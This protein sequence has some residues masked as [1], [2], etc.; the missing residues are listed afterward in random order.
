MESF[1]KSL[2]YLFA[3]DPEPFIGF[4]VGNR[5]V[6]VLEPVPVALPARGREVDAS[7]RVELEGKLMIVHVE[8]HRR[9]QALEE[10]AIDVAEAQI[11]FY[12]RERLPILSQVWDLHGSA[13]DAVLE[14]RVVSWGGPSDK[15]R[16]QSVYRRINLRGMSAEALLEQAPPILWP[17]SP[18]TRNGASIDVVARTGAAIE[19]RSELDSSHVADRLA[20][21][22]FMA[23][24][25]KVPLDVLWTVIS[26]EKLMES[27]LYRELFQD[28]EIRGEAR[29]E[30]Q[31]TADTI[32]RILTH[33]LGMVPP[34]VKQVVQGP[35]EPL[36]LEGWYHAALM[37]IT[38]DEAGRLVERILEQ[39]PKEDAER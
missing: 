3:Q 19:G 5:K 17:L 27:A 29:G 4:G 33:R 21:L 18:L 22:W 10:L 26:K 12:R 14:D 6:R 25:E 31:R 30:A 16:S 24:A 39:A 9:H 35:I 34:R 28:A 37:A 38:A 7:Y 20:V 36:V 32:L 8:F 23:D 11:R 2:K 13:R 15:L 1:D